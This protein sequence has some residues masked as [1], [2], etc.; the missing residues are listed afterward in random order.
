MEPEV[1]NLES[2]IPP[3]RQLPKNA[4]SLAERRVFARVEHREL[5]VR[6]GVAAGIRRHHVE[7]FRRSVEALSPK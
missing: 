7:A 2:R 1:G 3:S 5:V 4:Q 6:L